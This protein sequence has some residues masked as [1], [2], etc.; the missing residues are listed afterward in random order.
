MNAQLAEGLF[1]TPSENG[2]GPMVYIPAAAHLMVAPAVHNEQVAIMQVN[3]AGTVS[4]K[5]SPLV[6]QGSGLAVYPTPDPNHFLLAKMFTPAAPL[7]GGNGGL[8]P[9]T[10]AVADANI[11][12]IVISSEFGGR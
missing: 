5:Y 8:V 11:N 6:A 2:T 12:P 4:L 9:A 1:T 10:T 7:T 3:P